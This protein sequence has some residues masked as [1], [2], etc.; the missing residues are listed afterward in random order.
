MPSRTGQIR[1]VDRQ[2]IGNRSGRLQFPEFPGRSAPGIPDGIVEASSTTESGGEG[3]IAHPKLGL[4]NQRFGEMEALRLRNRLRT[5][6]DI[7]LE[8][9]PKV[10][11]GNA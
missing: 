9:V 6:A 10:A 8:Q 1:Q 7:T 2:G 4:V 11:I 5:R 3:N